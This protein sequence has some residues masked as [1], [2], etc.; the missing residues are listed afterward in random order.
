MVGVLAGAG[1]DVDVVGGDGDADGVVVAITGEDQEDDGELQNEVDLLGFCLEPQCRCLVF[2]LMGG[3]SLHDRTF[4]A[5]E[6]EARA[7]L[8]LLGLSNLSPLRW[9]VRLR[10]IR[11]VARGLAYLHSQAPGKPPLL[12]R[13]VKP[14]NVL[15][16]GSGQLKLA[17]FG[18]ATWIAREPKVHILGAPLYMAP[19]VH[20]RQ[21]DN[22]CDIWSLGCVLYMLVAGRLPFEGYTKKEVFQKITKG[23]YRVPN[24]SA[25]CQDLIAKMLTV[26]EKSR[27]TA[28]ECY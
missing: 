4:Y 24:C 14:Q 27:P 1:G 22:K 9:D 16:D 19:E 21:Y 13:D 23:S 15:L 10:L 12:H 11:D 8:E 17:D 3:G 28:A 5:S 7:R 18:F 2:P 6:N 25:P 26:D 20:A